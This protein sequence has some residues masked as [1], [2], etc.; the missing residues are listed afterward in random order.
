VQTPFRNCRQFAKTYP[1]FCKEEVSTCARW[2][3]NVPLTSPKINN[4][5]QKNGIVNLDN[6]VTKTLGL[7]WDSKNDLLKYDAKPI[8]QK[9]RVTKS[10]IL[11]I[12]AQI[13]DPLGIIGAV[14]ARAKII[15]QKLWSLKI[16][17]DESVPQDIHS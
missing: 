8:D 1:P 16:G 7:L 17:W 10:S 5:C 6:D 14:I 4:N 15:L 3:S 11:S 13:F 12:I 9:S 2:T